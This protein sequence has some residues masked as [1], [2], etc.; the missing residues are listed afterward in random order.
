MGA[1]ARGFAL[2]KLPKIKEFRFQKT[3]FTEIGV[4]TGAIPFA[5]KGREK[6]RQKKLVELHAAMEA[7]KAEPK[8][9]KKK[10]PVVKPGEA[11]KRKRK[12][13]NARMLDEWE[14][15]ALEERL[16]KKV[17]QGRMS[18]EEFQAALRK[19]GADSE[20]EDE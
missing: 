5:D 18:E 14:K 9:A 12:G 20:A 2:L 8:P 13:L 17:R 16:A 7:K 6:D 1:L 19:A 15:L 3:E 11:P 4:D 10:R